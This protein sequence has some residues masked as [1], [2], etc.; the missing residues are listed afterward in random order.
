M[1][2]TAFRARLQGLL[3]KHT[4]PLVNYHRMP[5]QDHPTQ[6]GKP[7]CADAAVHKTVH[8]SKHVTCLTY[9]SLPCRH[10]K[11]LSVINEFCSSS[12]HTTC[13][14][15]TST[16]AQVYQ[17]C[18]QDSVLPRFAPGTNQPTMGPAINH[19]IEQQRCD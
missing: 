9:S 19:I 17:R 1:H 11:K 3:I 13:R 2:S 4:M 8:P 7:G 16:R 12:K 15:S 10:V 5:S 14:A 6:R 18:Q